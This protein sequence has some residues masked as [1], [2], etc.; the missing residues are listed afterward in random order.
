MNPLQEKLLEAFRK[1]RKQKPEN[2]ITFM[3]DRNRPYAACA[4]GAIVVG[5]GADE[6]VVRSYTG[7][8]ITNFDHEEPLDPYE[9]AKNSLQSLNYGQIHEALIT[10]LNDEAVR[11][12]IDPDEAVRK[13]IREHKTFINPENYTHKDIFVASINIEEEVKRYL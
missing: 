6:D 8:P 5:L 3:Y 4:L 7:L 1:G 9:F 2:K 12:G 10:T 13:L 11:K